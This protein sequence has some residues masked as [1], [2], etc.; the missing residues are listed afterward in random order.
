MVV[1]QKPQL[2]MPVPS[3]E[4]LSELSITQQP[5]STMQRQA[6]LGEPGK[7]IRRSKER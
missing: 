3:N 7:L 4:I 2:V 1:L 5:L 6:K